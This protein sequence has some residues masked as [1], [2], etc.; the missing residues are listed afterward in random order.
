MQ[1]FSKRTVM[2]TAVLLVVTL[3]LTAFA[4]LPGQAADPDGVAIYNAI[5]VPFPG[6]YPSV[7]FQATST[8]EYGDHIQFAG[9]ERGLKSVVLGMSSWSC[10]N[11]FTLVGG[12]WQPKVGNAPCTTDASTGTGYD[13]PITLNLYA[14]DRTSGVP[15]PGAL[16]A[17][18]EQTFHIPYR[19][20]GDAVHCTS[21]AYGL[22]WY[23]VADGLCYNGYAFSIEFDFAAQN[24]TLPN[25]IIFGVAYNTYTH[26]AAP[27]GVNG[28][29]SSLNVGAHTLGAPSIGIDVEPNAQ[30]QDSTWAGAY[31]D[32]ATTLL[33]VF[34]RDDGCWAGY[35]IPVRFN[36]QPAKVT[37]TP[38]ANMV[39][40]ADS[41]TIDFSG[42]EAMYGYEFVVEYDATKVNATGSFI[43]TWFNTSGAFIPWDGSCAAGVCKFAVTLQG[44]PAGV[45]G[46][47]PVA[48]IDLTDK[49][50][51]AFQL[52][53]K[54]VTLS[55]IDGFTIPATVVDDTIDL[56]VCGRA[57]FAGK[58]SLQGRLTPMDAGTVK[59]VD[60]GGTFPDITV[61][62][63]AA[64][65]FSATNIPVL[66]TGSSYTIQAAHGLYLT[67]EKLQALAPGANLT[68]Q[69]TRLLGGDANN[70][71]VVEINDLTCIGGDFGLTTTSTP[72]MGNCGGTGSPDINLDLKVNIQ[73]LSI[74][75][76]NYAKV[77]P[78]GW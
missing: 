20:S 42:V 18:K 75:G 21:G 4:V 1:P 72:T 50:G 78:Q 64:G 37:L 67:N 7:G 62:F 33:D 17:S 31:C 12:V 51:G 73:D 6:N 56:D 35:T 59:L 2:L 65:N 28:P 76:G 3:L 48:K 23:S 53:I 47:G 55:D 54:D 70:S 9:S 19:P 24:V 30:F 36:L 68:G 13:H 44:A 39:C 57:A 71:A 11:D 32:T 27:L 45:S 69:N 38:S 8:D 49:A 16:L 5:P 25:E 22:P 66:P 43:N 10:G 29:Y 46:D 34:R 40:D 52:K 74:A 41:V 61:P 14:V 15:Q 58:V 26:G 63:N 60:A 77:A